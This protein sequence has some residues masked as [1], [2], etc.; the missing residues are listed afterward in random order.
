MYGK[1]I[2]QVQDNNYNDLVKYLAK[3]YHSFKSAVFVLN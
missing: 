2:I 3:M 1:Q